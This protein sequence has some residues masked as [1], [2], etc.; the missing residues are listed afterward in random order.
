M[1]DLVSLNFLAVNSVGS[2]DFKGRKEN[3]A[4]IS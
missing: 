1:G 4:S 2:G 3:T